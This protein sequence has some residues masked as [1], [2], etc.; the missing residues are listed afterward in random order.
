MK[1]MSDRI[2]SFG[3]E[4]VI[5]DLHQKK[6][7][8]INNDRD[9]GILPRCLIFEQDSRKKNK[10]CA[11]IGI[12]PGISSE[13]ERRFY[14]ENGINYTQIYNYWNENLKEKRRY[15][16]S[17]RNLVTLIGFKGPIL[18]TELVKCE[19]K[20]STKDINLQTFRICVDSYL[21]REIKL[22]PSEWPLFAVGKEPYKALAYLFPKRSVIGIPHPTG[23]RG[24]FSKLFVNDS[25]ENSLK[26]EVQ[27]LIIDS[28]SSKKAAWISSGS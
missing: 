11:V 24:H 25:G 23:S 7:D 26:E 21:K 15:Y 3:E 1:I 14:K 12:N 17:L 19:K 10:G 8:D 18:W 5:C 16:F 6:C 27:N 9:K 4:L 28:L 22:L 20:E 13:E 2:I